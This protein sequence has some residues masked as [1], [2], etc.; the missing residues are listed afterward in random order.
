VKN[1]SLRS[2][3]ALVIRELAAAEASE[4]ESLRHLRNAGEEWIAI[5]AELGE[6]GVNIDDWSKKNMPV[7]R[8]WLDRHAELYKNWRKLVAARKWAGEV[9]YTSRRQSGLDFALE[10]IA[11]KGRSDL[12]S[13]ESRLAAETT[14]ATTIDAQTALSRVTFMTGDA[15]T[16]LKGIP[17]GSIDCC[18]TSPPWYGSLRDYGDPRQVGHEPTIEA[19]IAKLVAIFREVRRVLADRGSLWLSIGDPYASNSASWG[20]A[21]GIHTRQGK[22]MME[23]RRPGAPNG[24]K[25]KDLIL[26]SAQV[27]MA[28]QKDGW[29]LRNEIV[30]YKRG[31]RPENVNDRYTRTHEKIY[32]LTK[33]DRY[34]FAQDD[35]REPIV[36]KPPASGNIGRQGVV[37]RDL[38]IGD[39]VRVWAANV[40]GRNPRDVWEFATSKYKGAHP[41]TYPPELVRRC[42]KAS[43][44][45]DGHVID[46]FAGAG[47]TGLVALELGHRAT[48]IDLNPAYINE[49]RQRLA[50]TPPSPV[51]GASSTP[52]ILTDRVTLHHGDCRDILPTIPD[53]TIDVVIA[54]PPFF[55]DV[56][57]EE[58]VIDHYIQKNG[59]KPR[60]RQ[61]WDKFD[62]AEDYLDFADRLLENA[63]RIIALTGSV[64]VFAVH[65]N[66]GLIDLAI[67]NTGLRVLHHLS[68]AKRN[69]TPMISTRRLQYSHET[70]V[71]CVK[72]DQ[73]R[74]N[75]GALKAA[76]YD[77]DRFKVAGKQHKDIIETNTS[78]HESVGH[79]AQKPVA[80]LSR[81]L[82]IAGRRGGVVLD[83]CA[84]SGTAAIAAS[85][86][87]MRSILIERDERY[88]ELI[89][90]RVQSSCGRI[91]RGRDDGSLRV[92]VTSA[93]DRTVR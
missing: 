92:S 44:P 77:G 4:M 28:L 59:M 45:P 29:W 82:D 26:L 68:W 34:W 54:D 79:P 32:L 86:H 39:T 69:P 64:F 75:Y 70:I 48:L 57:A 12:L 78:S 17:D 1:W 24:Y 5:K 85:Q 55:L 15:L 18:V 88:V 23:G 71:W 13:K 53:E 49:A 25:A 93:Y 52:I 38:R 73:Y 37:R 42:L 91:D 27:V 10:L 74:F 76:T 84:G 16:M 41:A 47:T 35:V 61:Q 50:S 22:N 33:S 62:D 9:G 31:I 89:K 43:C 20:T 36:T 66:L 14:S 81:L 90:R 11:A 58:N 46:P 30:W 60:F 21:N 3:K 63:A 67:R 56:P 80:L 83:P 40:L 51:Q 8:Q 2:A 19:Y 7:T 65:N 72:T 6:R 87:G